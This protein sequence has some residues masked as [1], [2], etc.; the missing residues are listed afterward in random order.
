MSLFLQKLADYCGIFSLHGTVMK[1]HATFTSLQF[2]FDV[3]TS[4]KD[5]MNFQMN[6][7]KT[8]L[9]SSSQKSAQSTSHLC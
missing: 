9:T 2:K 7:L 5:F 4:T 3:F 8:P 6:S 1:L